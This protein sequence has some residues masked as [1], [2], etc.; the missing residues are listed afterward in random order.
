[1]NAKDCAVTD[2]AALYET[3]DA[4]SILI[5][6]REQ[7]LVPF[8]EAEKPPSQWRIGVEMEKFGVAASD[9]RPLQYEGEHG[10]VR[11]MAGL[12]SS[13]KWAPESEEPNGPVIALRGEAGSVTLEPGAQFELSAAPV[14]DVHAVDAALRQHLL[15]LADVSRQMNVVWLAA[16][17]HPFATEPELPWVP[18]QRYAVMKSYLPPRGNA[19]L[20]MMRRTATVQANFDYSGQADA[21][22]KL[23]LLLR[24]SP[25]LNAMTANAPF[26]E[27]KVTDK[28]SVRGEVWLHMDPARSGLIPNLWDKPRP[29]YRDYV[30]W[31]LD[32]GMFLFKREGRVIVNAGQTFRSFLE[33]GYQGHHATLADWKLHLNTMFPEVRLK[34]TLE[35][36]PCD[37]LPTA[38]SSALV[39]LLTG[40]LYDARSFG[41]VEELCVGFRYDQVQALRPRLIAR[42]I[43]GELG[44]RRLPELAE[45]L[46]DIA[47]DGLER[48]AR[49][50]ASGCDERRYLDPLRQ[51]VARAQ[52]PADLLTLGLVEGQTLS[53]SELIA[54]TR[55][56]I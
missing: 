7:L 33:D 31:A 38:L 18:K 17:F 12:S 25:L 1:V 20:D 26:F 55:L 37:A 43:G 34:N 44:G 14:A 23:R 5:R 53:R 24:L 49:L 48:R 9:G 39:A 50:D 2:R 4:D 41:L 19:A 21:L 40:I 54:R 13:G 8:Y 36:R 42:G 27:G 16:G 56:G 3:H 22:R 47:A 6:D 46:V 35:V 51:L 45:Q 30:E 52:S 32:A 15:E 11:V 28:K 10:V 29:G